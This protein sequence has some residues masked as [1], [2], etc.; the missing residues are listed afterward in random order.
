MAQLEKI[1]YGGWKNCYR[2]S[3]GMIEMV[4]P[5][6]IGI[7]V[8][9]FGFIGDENEFYENKGDLGK[10]GG[11]EWRFYGGHRLW[12]AP[13]AMP[14]TYEPDN[15]PVTVEQDGSIVR[16]TQPIEPNTRLQ[17][18][19]EIE[20]AEDAPQVKLRHIIR[21]HGAWLVEFSPWALSVM[22]PGGTA[23]IPLPPRGSHPENLVPSSTLT[24]WAYTD[25]SD[26]R[27]TLGQKY[28][29]LRQDIDAASPQKIGAFVPDGWIAYTNNGHLF[30]KKV[31]TRPAS[32]YPD[33]NSSIETYTDHLFL[34]IETLAEVWGVAS[35]GAAEHIEQWF[36]YDDVP[37]PRNDAE[38]DTFVMPKLKV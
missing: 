1:E 8:I 24:L 26:P 37:T 31:E 18:I 23:I 21:N 6:E 25:L 4:I 7:R 9:R 13:E 34:E 11:D 12:H 15:A 30:V 19:I 22:K 36:L 17:K 33:M 2:L 3:N 16:V 28:I 38:V 27:W 29:L 5:G 32:R 14:R 35:G 20:M 10:T